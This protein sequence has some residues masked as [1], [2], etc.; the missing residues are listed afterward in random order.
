MIFPTNKRVPLI[1]DELVKVVLQEGKVLYGIVEDVK[2]DVVW[3]KSSHEKDAIVARF[4][5]KI[6]KFYKLN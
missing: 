3:L 5:F 2:G 4:N 6:D 1:K